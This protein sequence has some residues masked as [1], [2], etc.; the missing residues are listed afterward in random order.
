MVT[1]VRNAMTNAYHA[2]EI[3][4]AIVYTV[5]SHWFYMMPNAL[6]NVLQ[7]ILT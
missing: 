4:R 1:S 2:Q 5:D 3:W 6:V 7:V